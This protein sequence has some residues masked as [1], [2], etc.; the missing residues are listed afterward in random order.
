[1]LTRFFARDILR[2]MRRSSIWWM[3]GGLW[4]VIA[5]VVALHQGWRQAW[6]QATIAL[7]FFAVALRMR[8]KE[9]LR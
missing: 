2:L 4:L 3:I 6:L 1:M 5:I 9:N 7:V 8:S